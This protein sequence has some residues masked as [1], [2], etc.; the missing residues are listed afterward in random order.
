MSRQIGEHLGTKRRQATAVGSDAYQVDVVV[1]LFSIL[2]ILLLTS[3]AQVKVE[4]ERP[5]RTDYRPVDVQTRPFQLRAVAPIYPYRGIW[6]VR[7]GMLHALD[8]Q[9]I[10]ER[11]RG[12]GALTLE[13][14]LDPVDLTVKPASP[15][16][17]SFHLR[18]AFSGPGVHE[19]LVSEG[20][21]LADTEAAVAALRGDSGGALIYAWSDGAS[22]LARVLARLRAEGVCHKLVL[23]P[24]R[25]TLAMARD[26]ALFAEEAVLRC[27]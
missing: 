18:L 21:P 20:I 15:H 3:L 6:I 11:Y 5:S 8:L 10:A 27:Y 16:L 19:E 12:A 9:A 14:W 17:D 13:E 1:A 22:G 2:L 4:T 7:D 24:R 23:D 26:Y 25:E